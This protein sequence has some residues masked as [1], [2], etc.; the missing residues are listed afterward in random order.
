MDYGGLTYKQGL[1]YLLRSQAG[2]IK[3]TA[4]TRP[5]LYANLLFSKP[6][7]TRILYVP[8]EQADYGLCA[9]LGGLG[10]T[11]YS[12]FPGRPMVYSISRDGGTFFFIKRL[13]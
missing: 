11:A 3:V 9:P 10:I 2:P 5:G 7:W 6:D 1:E 12:Y 4:C 13:R 8:P